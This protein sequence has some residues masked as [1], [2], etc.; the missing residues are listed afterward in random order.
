MSARMTVEIDP[1]TMTI[2]GIS[3]NPIEKIAN[4]PGGRSDDTID[5]GHLQRQ[6]AQE[7]REAQVGRWTRP[8]T[9]PLPDRTARVPVGAGSVHINAPST[10]DH[11]RDERKT[12]GDGQ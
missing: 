5:A 4:S 3:T 11:E 1:V 9:S 12:H 10:P 6:G 8:S 7:A 2:R